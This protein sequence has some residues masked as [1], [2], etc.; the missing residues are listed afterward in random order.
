MQDALERLAAESEAV[1]NPRLPKELVRAISRRRLL[2]SK[3]MGGG[4]E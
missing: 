3:G 2:E 4:C 1:R